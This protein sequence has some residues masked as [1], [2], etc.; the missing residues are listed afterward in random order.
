MSDLGLKACLFIENFVDGTMMHQTIS[1]CPISFIAMLYK[2]GGSMF[3]GLLGCSWI[4][5][6]LRVLPLPKK[7]AIG[8]IFRGSLLPL[9]IAEYLTFDFFTTKV[10]SFT[11]TSYV[12]IARLT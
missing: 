1:R 12:P 8:W 4:D 5:M 6:V 10:L 7:G 2:R 9:V 3:C 11:E